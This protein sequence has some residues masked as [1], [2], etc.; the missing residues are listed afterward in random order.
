MENWKPIKSD[1]HKYFKKYESYIYSH[2]TDRAD[3]EKLP[4]LTKK[5]TDPSLRSVMIKLPNS[6]FDP[7]R[8]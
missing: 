5:K 1:I 4:E 2:D 6:Q 3:D 8:K 7:E